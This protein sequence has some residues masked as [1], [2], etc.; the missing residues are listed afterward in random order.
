MPVRLRR[1]IPI[2]SRS[3]DFPNPTR[4][5]E[6]ASAGRFHP[7]RCAISSPKF[8]PGSRRRRARSDSAS[9][10]ANP[11]RAG[12]DLGASGVVSY[13]RAAV[14]EVLRGSGLTYVEPDARFTCACACP[15]APTRWRRRCACRR[16]GRRYRAGTDVRHTTLE[17]WLRL[18]WV[19]PNRPRSEKARAHRVG[20]ARLRV[21]RWNCTFSKKR[22][23]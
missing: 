4:S 20:R 1:A 11:Q 14:L 12:C 7:R 9:R 6:C 8:M 5:P 13:P 18:S 22:S 15:T 17:G 3:T 16:Y 19:A 23:P 2:P 21:G 10:A